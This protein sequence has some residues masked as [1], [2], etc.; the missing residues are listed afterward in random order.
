MDQKGPLLQ[1]KLSLAETLSFGITVAFFVWFVT[2]KFQSK[3]EAFKLE[4]RV[5][6]VEADISLVKEG[7][8]AISKDVSYIRGRLEPRAK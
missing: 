3:E 1:W 8:S 6:K 4:R 7:I 2:E 5:E